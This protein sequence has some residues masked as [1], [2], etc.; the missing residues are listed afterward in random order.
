MFITLTL[1]LLIN[2]GSLEATILA[3]KEGY[4]GIDIKN[5]VFKLLDRFSI[6]VVNSVNNNG[7]KDYSNLTLVTY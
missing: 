7:I 5:I 1:L 3:L 4:I 6:L 2:K